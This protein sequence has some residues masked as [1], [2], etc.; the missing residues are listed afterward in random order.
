[1]EELAGL[2]R[3][4]TTRTALPV[5]ALVLDTQVS[6]ASIRLF[7]VILEAAGRLQADQM[8]LLLT[9]LFLTS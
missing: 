5:L 4:Q 7:M 3:L 2:P 6:K 1:L 9:H 8:A